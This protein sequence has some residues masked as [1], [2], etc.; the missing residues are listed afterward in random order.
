MKKNLLLA[1]TVSMLAIAGCS[2]NNEDD[3]TVIPIPDPV[4]KAYLLER[5]D[6]NNDGEIS[7]S[8]AKYVTQIA[9]TNTEIK[10]FEGVEYFT[11]LKDFNCS[12]GKVT[13]LDLSKNTKLS[14][15]YFSQT[16]IS[17]IDL[18]KNVNLTMLTCDQT[19]LSSIDVSKN[20]NLTYLSCKSNQITELDLSNNVNLLDLECDNNN[21][22]ELDLSKNILL[23]F[24]N[25]SYNKMT[26]LYLVDN[27]NLGSV[28]CTMSTLVNL[29]L[30]AGHHYTVIERDIFAT[31]I[32]YL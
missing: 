12:G 16:D 29:Y 2:S 32:V 4:F 14:A 20:I 21:L 31:T 22:T 10:S 13:T 27:I 18:S 28:R 24:L 25:C 11:E 5:H 8:E 3:N 6:L 15:I 19:K 9:P 30:I 7:F 17:S 23:S 1:L 26:Y